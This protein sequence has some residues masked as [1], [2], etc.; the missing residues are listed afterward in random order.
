MKKMS[1]TQ[2]AL[3]RNSLLGLFF[4]MDLGQAVTCKTCDYVSERCHAEYCICLRL[5]LQ[6]S[7]KYFKRLKRS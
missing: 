6:S 5:S 7:F 1:L 4:G 2:E 3:E